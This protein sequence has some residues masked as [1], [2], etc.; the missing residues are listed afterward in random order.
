MQD[1]E[2]VMRPYKTIGALREAMN[3]RVKTD[4]RFIKFREALA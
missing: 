2:V 4:A 3:E 1:F